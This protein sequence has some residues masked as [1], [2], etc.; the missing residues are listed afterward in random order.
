MIFFAFKMFF[1]LF[2]N[3]YE[4]LYIL[5]FRSK[6]LRR[7]PTK[8]NPISQFD[9]NKVETTP[10]FTT[11]QGKTKSDVFYGNNKTISFQL[12][13]NIVSCNQIGNKIKF[14]IKLRKEQ[15]VFLYKLFKQLNC[16][17]KIYENKYG[18][19]FLFV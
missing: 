19:K 5:I 2:A 7:N 10:Q 12:D 13:K 4:Y 3:K 18:D 14:G 1:V 6:K 11:R 8:M 17:D 9:F 15:D 16:M